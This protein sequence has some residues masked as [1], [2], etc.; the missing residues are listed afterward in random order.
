MKCTAAVRL[1]LCAEALHTRK[2]SYF[3]RKPEHLKWGKPAQNGNCTCKLM[4]SRYG[5]W[6]LPKCANFSAVSYTTYFSLSQQANGEGFEHWPTVAK[7][8]SLHIHTPPDLSM[9]ILKVNVNAVTM[10][11]TCKCQC[12][13]SKYCWLG[14]HPNET[15]IKCKSKCEVF[16]TPDLRIFTRQAF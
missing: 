11:Q 3:A 8:A 4:L 2:H 1:P 13:V 7:K 10:D 14:E 6:V 9:Y 16:T 15:D 5:H 12:L